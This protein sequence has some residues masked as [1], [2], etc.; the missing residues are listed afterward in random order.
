MRSHQIRPHGYIP[1]PLSHARGLLSLVLYCSGPIQHRRDQIAPIAEFRPLSWPT[2]SP[3]R[4][5]QALSGLYWCLFIFI[6]NRHSDRST[7]YVFRPA[8]SFSLTNKLLRSFPL[9]HSYLSIPPHVDH[10]TPS[11]LIFTS[12]LRHLP[13]LTRPRY[14]HV[15]WFIYLHFSHSPSHDRFISQHSV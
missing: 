15:L 7:R 13:Q 12:I 2:S 10:F 14:D 11:F 9:F 3:M 5:D 4:T 8:Y 1:D 6:S